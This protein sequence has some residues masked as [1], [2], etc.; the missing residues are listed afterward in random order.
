MK[1]IIDAGSLLCG[2]RAAS[3]GPT[4]EQA[5]RR[6]VFIWQGPV[7]YECILY[8]FFFFWQRA[9]HFSRIRAVFQWMRALNLPWWRPRWKRGT[10][11]SVI[12]QRIKVSLECSSTELFL[13]ILYE[14]ADQRNHLD[15]CRRRSSAQRVHH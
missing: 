3:S 7:Y 9:L 4:R 5:R 10:P 11:L 15:S 13:W 8:P 2:G 1:I 14:S 12:A 6:Y